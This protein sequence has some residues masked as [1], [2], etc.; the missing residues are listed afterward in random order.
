MWMD[1][2]SVEYHWILQI[3]LWNEILSFFLSLQ[4]RMTFK[5]NFKN[6]DINTAPYMY[7]VGKSHSW[8]IIILGIQFEP[9]CD[10]S[11]L[12]SYHS[13]YIFIDS[14]G[15]WIILLLHCCANHQVKKPLLQHIKKSSSRDELMKINFHCWF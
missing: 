6:L 12:L 10:I 11:H 14:N 4:D 13:S 15:F 8:L 3:T 9:V 5:S 1:F 7:E 2:F